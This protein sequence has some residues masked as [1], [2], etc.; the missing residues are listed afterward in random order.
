MLLIASVNKT[1]LMQSKKDN[2]LVLLYLSVS[3]RGVIGQFC[4]P[5]FII[6]PAKFESCSFLARPINLRDKNILLALFSRSVL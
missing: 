6:A 2:K 3:T 5:Y 1:K 4:G